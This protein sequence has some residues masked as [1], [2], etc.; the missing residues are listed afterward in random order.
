MSLTEE[1]QIVQSKINEE[2]QD[3]EMTKWNGAVD[4]QSRQ[5]F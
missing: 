1:V 5:E 3:K 2:A 4:D